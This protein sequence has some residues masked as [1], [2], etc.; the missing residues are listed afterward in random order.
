MA[1]TADQPQRFQSMD[2]TPAPPAL[3]EHGLPLPA[4]LPG[5]LRAAGAR[6]DGDLD[7]D[8]G[9]DDDTI[10]ELHQRHRG[11]G[12]HVEKGERVWGREGK[13]RG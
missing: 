12:A 5:V 1:R 9:E 13:V 7:V 3:S 6:Y 11:R 8:L 2:A 10:F 4:A